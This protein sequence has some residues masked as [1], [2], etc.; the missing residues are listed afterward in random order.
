MAVNKKGG[1]VNSL[2]DSD[3]GLAEL[4]RL[5]EQ[6]EREP[7]SFRQLRLRARN[8][9]VAMKAMNRMEELEPGVK[10]LPFFQD[11]Y[12]KHERAKT[13]LQPRMSAYKESMRERLNTQ[14]VNTIGR[15]FSESRINSYVAQNINGQSAQTAGM[16]LASQPYSSLSQTRQNIMGQMSNLRQESVNA[17]GEYIQNRGV[18]P[19]SASTLRNNAVEMKVLAQQ[20]VPIT[21]AMQQLK[22]QGLDPQGRQRSLIQMGDKAQGILAYNNL[23]SDI[24]NGKGLGAFSKGELKE[25]ESEAAQKL[26]KA[27]DELRNSVG[28][29]E[30]EM[31]SLT[32][33]A[34]EAGDDLDKISKAKGM[35][36]SGGGG[37]TVSAWGSVIS[38]AAN[39]V[40]NT[41]H[42]MGVAQPMQNMANI[43]GYANLENQKY[44]QWRAA[45][46]GDMTSRMGLAGWSNAKSFGKTLAN[47]EGVVVGS[48]IVAGVATM[49]GGIAQGADAVSSAPQ[50]KLFGTAHSVTDLGSAALTTGE[51]LAM[52]LVSGKDAYQK[53]ST[54]AVE[55]A[56]NQQSMATTNALNHVQ[57]YQAQQYRDYLVNLNPAARSLGGLANANKFMGET[58]GAGFMGQMSSVGMGTG[59]FAGLA[60]MGAA[61]MGSQFNPAQVISAKRLENVGYGSASENMQRMGMLAG[62]QNPSASMEK[63]IEQGM[64]KGLSS[65]RS[66]NLIAENTGQMVE[67]NIMGGNTADSTESLSRLLTGLVN[68]N[69][70]NKE[71]AT[72][73]AISSFR[74]GENRTTGT[75]PG[76]AD[77]MGVANLQRTLGL[78]PF[79]AMRMKAILPSTLTGWTEG[80]ENH[81]LTKEQLALNL[82]NKGIDTQTNKAFQSNPLKFL[83]SAGE[84]AALGNTMAGSGIAY[85]A[86]AG[87]NAVRH[88]A[89]SDPSKQNERIDMLAGDRLDFKNMPKEVY[90]QALAF[91][92]ALNQDEPGVNVGQRIRETL[93]MANIRQTNKEGTL[94]TSDYEKSLFGI[95]AYSSS[96][97]EFN[98]FGQQQ[99]KAADEARN[100]LSDGSQGGAAAAA[101][102]AGSGT[103]AQNAVGAGG[104]SLWATAAAENARTFGA[105]AVELNLASGKLVEAANT[106]ITWAGANKKDDQDDVKN[107][108]KGFP[109]KPEPRENVGHNQ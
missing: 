17:A 30:K 58:A 41:I 78:D 51:G 55:I 15:E 7:S 101:A 90:K 47:R 1:G 21:A 11:E 6:N 61:N 97:K 81:T 100:R 45:V 87:F 79:S 5:A 35:S 57:G 106:L 109:N 48:R 34:E 42:T 59:E 18:N 86:N 14:A 54:S 50:G 96:Q 27:L 36:G 16:N 98:L 13:R 80:Y 3:F 92:Q 63:I 44:D 89:S 69:M 72:N 26:I 19:N 91:R 24:R 77:R 62:A 2:D 8:A 105:S 82:F 60:A 49:A 56:A 33:K 68:P 108:N 66:L 95:G 85:Q 103:D 93:A 43:G 46:G 37:Q 20:L 40:G 64:A 84:I 75:G 12:A 65:S 67:K 31:E 9:R 29:T 23:E 94:P 25:K 74:S 39:L 83:R 88:W 38:Q 70:A 4:G 32:K 22:Q 10:D 76:W 104:E 99:T 52:G 53:T 28:K 102:V 71:M 107:I 73:V